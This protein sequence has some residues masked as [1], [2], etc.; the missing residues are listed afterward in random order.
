MIKEIHV[1]DVDGVLLDSVHRHKFNEDGTLD[2]FH[3][4][5]NSTPEKLEQDK[6]LPMVTRYIAS[7]VNPNVYAV[8]CSV[9]SNE[10]KHINSIIRKL[11]KPDLMLLVGETKPPCTPG[12]KLKRKKLGPLFNLKQFQNVPRYLWEDSQ[13]NIDTLKDLFTKTFL[14]TG[15]RINQDG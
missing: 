14:V 5:K 4:F 7:C 10:P 6:I 8:I 1:Y 2:F 13:K 11:G 15:H 9:R 3:Y 12:D